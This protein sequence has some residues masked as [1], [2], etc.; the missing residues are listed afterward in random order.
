MSRPVISSEEDAL[1]DLGTSLSRPSRPERDLSL[2]LDRLSWEEFEVFCYLLLQQEHPD[3]EVVH[4]GKTADLGRDIVHRRSDG[5]VDFVQCKRY[6]TDIRLGEVRKELAKLFTNLFSGVIP[7]RPTR[8]SFYL[9]RDLTSPAR[10]L[11]YREEWVKAAEQALTEHLKAAPPADLL[12]FARTWWPVE[13]IHAEPGI[14]LTARAERFPDLLEKFFRTQ[15]VIDGSVVDVLEGVTATMQDVF[16]EV[17]DKR[18]AL[19]TA[20]RILGKAWEDFFTL[21]KKPEAA[22]AYLNHWSGLMPEERFEA[23]KDFSTIQDSVHNQPLT[24]LIGPPAAGKTFIALQVLW[25]AFQQGVPVRWIAPTTFVPTDGPIPKEEGPSDMRQRIEGLTTTLGLKPF[26]APLDRHEFITANLEP[27][28]IVYIEDPFGKRDEEFEYSLHTYRFFDLDECVAAISNGAGRAGCHILLSSR[29]GLFDRWETERAKKGL[30]PIAAKLIRVAGESYSYEE[31]ERLSM[32]LAQARG[33]EHPEEVTDEIYHRVEF[34]YEI[35]SILN[36]LPLDA[37]GEQA[38]AEAL[39]YRDGLKS[40]LR[41]ILVAEN[42]HEMLFL[43]VLASGCTDPKTRYLRL[44]EALNLSG[45]AEDSLNRA[46]ERYRAFV[47][48]SPVV[49]SA[50]V[51]SNVFDLMRHYGPEA[52]EDFSPSHSTVA[53]AIIEYFRGSAAGFSTFLERLACALPEDPWNWKSARDGANIALQ[54][55]SF[56][57]CS[58]PGP[59][60]DAILK[61]LL[62]RGGLSLHHINDFMRLWPSLGSTFK[63]QLFTYLKNGLHVERPLRSVGDFDGNTRVLLIEMAS[64]LPSVELPAE[65]AWR[66]TRLLFRI[67]ESSD[68]RGLYNWGSPWS[69][70]FEHLERAPDDIR[71][72]LE[73]IVVARPGLFVRIMSEVAVANWEEIPESYKAAFFA[74]SSLRSIVVQ[75]RALQGIAQH[76]ETAPKELRDLFIRQAASADS[77]IRAA[78]VTAAWI[79]R[80]HDPVLGEVLLDSADDADVRVPL[81][82]MHDLGDEEDD[83]RFAR[84]FFERADAILAAEMLRDLLRSNGETSPEWK[85]DLA[86]ECLIKG[87]DR[88]WSVLA[89]LHFGTEEIV[90]DPL[91]DWRDLIMEEPEPIRLGALWAYGRSSGKSPKLEPDEV[92]FLINGLGNPSRSLALAYLSAQAKG[93]PTYLQEFLQTL[94]TTAGEDGD[95]VRIGKE[96]RGS[97]EGNNPWAFL[98]LA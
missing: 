92:L 84:R 19:S 47:V 23:P 32:R 27:G 46:V 31:R 35:E 88:A 82:I 54:L 96:K 26:R 69:Y 93:L 33:M 98:P 43:L 24:I 37:K 80:R 15:K 48:R 29:E 73:R 91:H 74:E 2:P 41:Q 75:E 83:R 49:N 17:L 5:G 38:E 20:G 94:E 61:V 16:T 67:F 25:A 87:G 64:S 97:N 68:G 28:S 39:K 11:L 95:A 22:L 45:D 4:Y 51:D 3:D 9:A 81:S 62:D 59:A 58:R 89:V 21:T 65:D 90:T 7:E 77:K 78:A 55:L 8:V 60:Q 13:G 70:L 34:P 42:D 52:D 1:R 44:H 79:Y 53:E 18:E 12:D 10:S 40:A 36:A 71:Q 76:W 14:R 85:L 56:G 72:Y 63:D 30:P 50:I 6:S 86:R 57:V 66:L